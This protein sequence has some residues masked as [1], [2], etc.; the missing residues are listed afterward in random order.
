LFNHILLRVEFAKIYWL[1]LVSSLS[2]LVLKADKTMV[3]IMGSMELGTVFCLIEV[4]LV[5]KED[6]FMVLVS[7]IVLLCFFTFELVEVR[8]SIERLTNKLS[9]IPFISS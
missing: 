4:C 6:K 1:T 8:L 5:S 2:N 9:S 7:L 3:L